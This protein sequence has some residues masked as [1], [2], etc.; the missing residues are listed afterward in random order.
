MDAIMNAISTDSAIWVGIGAVLGGCIGAVITFWVA[1]GRGF[2]EGILRQQKHYE[3]ILRIQHGQSPLNGREQNVETHAP[4]EIVEADK[5][6]GSEA[7]GDTR[8]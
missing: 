4:E 7:L 6:V 8:Y 2:R 3:E 1:E 5:V